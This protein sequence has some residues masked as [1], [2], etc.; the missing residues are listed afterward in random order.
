M[1][2]PHTPNG[3]PSKEWSYYLAS[4]NQTSFKDIIEID[5]DAT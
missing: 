5:H 4:T 1:K 3:P 2:G